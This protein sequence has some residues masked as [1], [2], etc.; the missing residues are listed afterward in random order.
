[1][2]AVQ[3]CALPIPIVTSTLAAVALGV[4][5]AGK[6]LVTV[7]ACACATVFL[8]ERLLPLLKTPLD[9]AI[10]GL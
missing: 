1:M 10:P 5:L 2:T 4:A 6:G 9:K 7:A 3:T 8:V